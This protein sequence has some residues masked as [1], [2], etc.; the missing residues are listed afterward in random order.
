MAQ[1]PNVARLMGLPVFKM[2]IFSYTLAGILGGISSV[3]LIMALGSAQA[4]YGN[5]LA[6]KVIAAAVFAGLGNLGGGLVAALI[7]GLAES[8][9]MGYLAGDWAPAVSLGMIM[10]VVMFRPQGIFGMRV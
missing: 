8:F 5:I 2:S 1:L 6:I 3:F 10:I 4:G 7:L 9:V